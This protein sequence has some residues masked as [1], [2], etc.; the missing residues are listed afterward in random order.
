[1]ISVKLRDCT[2]CINVFTS[3]DMENTPTES[4][5]RVFIKNRISPHRPTH[6]LQ[7][8]DV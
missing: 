2:V 3:E 7:A 8:Y 4:L 6:A 1:M 5:I